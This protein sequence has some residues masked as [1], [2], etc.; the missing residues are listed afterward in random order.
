MA[1]VT[2][3]PGELDRDSKFYV[4][5]HNGMVG[6]AVWRHLE[7]S[8]FSNLKGRLSNELDLRNRDAV[9]T[10]FEKE[11]P[12]YVVL[13]AARVGGIMAN[14]TYPAEFLSDNLQIQVNV[15]DAAAR[16]GVER[17]L[18]MGSSCIYPKFADQPIKEESLLTGYLEPTN[19][20]YAI[21]KIAG[22]MQVQATRRQYG[23]AWI[24]AMPTNLY[25][26]G[27]NYSGF[28]SHVIPA[29][30]KRYEE[31]LI[32]GE[33]VVTNWGSGSPLREFLYVD[34]LATATLHLLEKYDGPQQ[35]NVGTGSDLSIKEISELVAKAVGYE[36][37]SEWD[38][39]KPD[40]T[41]KKLL[42]ISKIKSFGWEPKISLEE[43][44][45]LAV[46]DFRS[47]N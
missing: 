39:S 28:N 15:M 43:G 7:A 8:G 34:D 25:G 21:A 44:L 38:T 29:L 11:K 47:K 41:P 37:T 12:R 2:W 26:V 45:K 19:D 17:L 3:V 24:S 20:A 40:G 32:S 22:I 14:N 23:L 35:V 42:D 10:F 4:A 13:A 46:A 27:D 16:F 18:F 36:G 9:F 1:E 30:I 5:G 6:A 33:S 31:A